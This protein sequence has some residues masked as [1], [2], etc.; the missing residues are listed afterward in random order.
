MQTPPGGQT[1]PGLIP[2]IDRCLSACLLSI[3]TDALA[4]PAT[5]NVLSA[6]NGRR[7]A[8][9]T[10]GV[11]LANRGTAIRSC[12][13]ALVSRS[14]RLPSRPDHSQGEIWPTVGCWALPHRPHGPH[15]AIRHLAIAT[16][17]DA[18][19]TRSRSSG[20]QGFSP[21]SRNGKAA[22]PTASLSRLAPLPRQAAVHPRAGRSSTPRSTRGPAGAVLDSRHLAQALP[23]RAR[24]RRFHNGRDP[25]CCRPGAQG[26]WR[27]GDRGSGAVGG[28]G[29]ARAIAKIPACHASPS[30][31]CWSNL[32]SHQTPVMSFACAP[33]RVPDCT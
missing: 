26:R 5:S 18:D 8:W 24:R 6:S 13:H 1:P 12:H 22:W 32:R 30:T 7:P 20:P 21:A 28:A 31:S 17:P 23:G 4:A 10:P 3:V 14:V 19:S 33:T 11:R 27:R 2:T 9:P 25:G 16:N 29:P 15:G